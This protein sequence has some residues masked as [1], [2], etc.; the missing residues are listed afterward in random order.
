[1]DYSYSIVLNKICRCGLADCSVY[2]NAPTSAKAL[3][4]D[5]FYVSRTVSDERRQFAPKFAILSPLGSKYTPE[6]IA[7]KINGMLV[8]CEACN[9]VNKDK[10]PQGKRIEINLRSLSEEAL[11][12]VYENC[13]L[14]PQR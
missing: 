6:Q 8:E 2:R 3:E 4:K 1:M 14:D 9:A 10:R 12:Y 5:V 13:D 11:K 7:D